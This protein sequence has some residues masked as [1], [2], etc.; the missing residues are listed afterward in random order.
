MNTGFMGEGIRSNDRFVTR[1]YHACQSAHKTACFRD[2]LQV[3]RRL[4]AEVIR[5][6]SKRHRYLFERCIACSL[7]DTV[8]GALHL[9]STIQNGSQ[10]IRRSHA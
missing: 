7:A 2:F 10:G 3:Q 8:N 9:V 5:T 4:S 1:D 6:R